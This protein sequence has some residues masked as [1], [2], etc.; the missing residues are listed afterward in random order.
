MRNLRIAALRQPRLDLHATPKDAASTHIS[1]TLVDP[2]DDGLYAITTSAS[3]VSDARVDVDVWRLTPKQQHVASF[4][5]PAGGGGVA[6]GQHH[7]RPDGA[8]P[9]SFASSSKAPPPPQIV[10]ST[11]L[12]DGGSF[13]Q[14]DPAICIVCAGGDIALV[15]PTVSSQD[16]GARNASSRDGAGQGESDDEPLLPEIVGS[17]EQGIRAAAWSP[18]QE[19]LVLVTAPT[20]AELADDGVSKGSTLL[21]M[22][23]EFEVLSEN[24][25]QTDDFGEERPIALGWGSKSTQF[26][27]S[28]GKQAAAAACAAGSYSNGVALQRAPLN[29]DDDGGARISW[30]GDSSI[31][32]VSTVESSSASHHRIV[33]TFGKNGNLLATSDPSAEGLSHA[34]AYKPTGILWATTQRVENEHRLAFFERNGLFKSSFALE[35]AFEPIRELAWN[36]D[37]SILAVWTA[38]KVQLWT[39]GNYHWYLKQQIGTRAP[40]RS[41]SWHPEKPGNLYVATT[42]DVSAYHFTWETCVSVAQPPN[43]AACAAVVDGI[44]ILLTPFRLQN[45]PPPMSSLKLLL[46]DGVVPIDLAWADAPSGPNES[47][48]ILFVLLP[49]GLVQAWAVEWG[50][51]SNKPTARDTGWIQPRMLCA[52]DF[53][54]SAR[55]VAGAATRKG[56]FVK[57]AVGTLASEGFESLKIATRKVHLPNGSI[58]NVRFDSLSLGR[59]A[60][61]MLVA[62]PPVDSAGLLGSIYV[63]EKKLMRNVQGIRLSL[64]DFCAHSQLISGNDE[65]P[66]AVGLTDKGYLYANGRL[67]ARNASSFTLTDTHLIWVNV[68]HEARFLPLTALDREGEGESEE[69]V[70]LSRRV[71]R[72][73]RIVTAVPSSMCLI[74]QMPRGNLETITPRPLLLEQVKRSLD[75]KHY[76]KAF[77]ICR[78][79]RLDMNI[80]LSH[81]QDHLLEDVELFVRQ[82]QDGDH[83]N[84]FLSSLTPEHIGRKGRTIG[85]AEVTNPEIE[86]KRARVNALC[87]AVRGVLEA[88]PERERYTDTVLTTHVRKSPPDHESALRLLS[89]LKE[90]DPV[91]AD[92]ACKYVIFLSDADKLFKT[93]LGMYDFTLPLLV[94]HH[95]PNRD[96]RE[97]LPFLRGLREIQPMEMQRFR[98]DETL[99]RWERALTWLIKAGPEHVEDALAF[100]EEHQLYRQALREYANDADKLARVQELYG[101]WLVGQ[102]RYKEAGVLF[103][104]CKQPRKGIDADVKA[105]QWQD[106][107]STASMC[108]GASSKADM[109]QLAK[110]VCTSLAS[111]GRSGEAAMVALD[112]LDDTDEGVRLLCKELEFGEAKRQAAL[113]GRH[114]LLHSCIRPMLVKAGK[115]LLSDVD[116]MREQSEKQFARLGELLIRKRER[117]ED[118]YPDVGGE[119]GGGGG[120][121]N[122]AASQAFTTF[123]RYTRYTAFTANAARRGTAAGASPGSTMSQFT[124]ASKKQEAQSA[125]SSKREMRKQHTGKKGS[126]YEEDYIYESLRKLLGARLEKLQKEAAQV[127]L[128]LIRFGDG[129]DEGQQHASNGGGVNGAGTMDADGGLTAPMEGDEDDEDGPEMPAAIVHALA[130]GLSRLEQFV[131]DAADKAWQDVLADDAALEVERVRAIQEGLA[132]GLSWQQLQD[133]GLFAPPLPRER[134]SVSTTFWRLSALLPDMDL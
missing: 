89:E 75:E 132:L 108:G 8:G 68:A 65:E 33:R 29:A 90:R 112:Y 15:P 134:I 3:Y 60:P 76:R 124:M 96:P 66:Q 22:T 102:H 73:S 49:A 63:H 92:D 42:S 12:A 55:Q 30:R 52:F 109:G 79:H 128:Q 101:N 133:N 16:Q 48:S 99:E 58:G 27:G 11:V 119:G 111:Y 88:S 35:H 105:G 41:L 82:I 121:D 25:L 71:E 1:A 57:M 20:P 43:D 24:V 32:V 87:D 5:T 44:K 113:H 129:T 117:P 78:T 70:E 18:D 100:V 114:D 2:E 84:L 103:A 19:L 39:V 118:Y 14:N 62:A 72:G 127:L 91:Q 59:A 34:L 6:G 26:H 69:V 67:L 40:I 13:M 93:A 28:E 130:E 37:G 123:T 56:D 17:V 85:I 23:R 53:G 61:R 10:S 86:A 74:L 106:A 131:T 36:S 110:R 7:H 80:I 54:L 115:A 97:Y 104:Q 46:K 95:S 81:R 77:R 31:F 51:L 116:E 45:V 50:K 38:A 4:S 125:K 94:A 47:T 126:I 107:L 21:L 120:D 9:S 64:P 83:L 98:I 122:D